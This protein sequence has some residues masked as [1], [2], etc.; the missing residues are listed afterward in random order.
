MPGRTCTLNYPRLSPFSNSLP[1]G[2][3]RGQSNAGDSV[4]DILSN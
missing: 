4:Q 1:G 2:Y 3:V